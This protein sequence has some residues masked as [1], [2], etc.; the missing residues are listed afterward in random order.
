MPDHDA[1]PDDDPGDGEVPGDHA[2]P[3]D[4]VDDPG[5]DEL[6]DPIPEADSE[7][8]AD[9]WEESEAMDGEAPTG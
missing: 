5:A 1:M 4:E 6:P 7:D 8:T 3:T 9:A 2:A